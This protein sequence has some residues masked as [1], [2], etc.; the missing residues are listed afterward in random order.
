MR[1]LLLSLLLLVF[2]V[3]LRADAVADLKTR[4]GALT[5]QASVKAG[6]SFTFWSKVGDDK[7]P[8]VQEASI[9]LTAEDG[10]QGL[11]VGWSRD[12]IQLLAAEAL[13]KNGDPEK[14]TPTRRAID[15]FGAAT[16]T[17]FLNAAPELLNN[18]NRATL[19]SEKTDTW[20]GQPAQLLTF[21]L[22]PALSER[23][24]RLIKDVYDTA[25]IWVGADG[26][27][28]AAHRTQR[29]KGRAMLVVTFEF[30]FNEQSEYAQVG[31][32]L[33]VVRRSEE[34]NNSGAGEMG[35]Q[36]TTAVLTVIAW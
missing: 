17:R 1:A 12:L 32:R 4:L 34:R 21:Q 20:Q 29:L 14:S 5:G 28:L 13:A 25:K 24:L 11:H 15:E 10:P 18:L 35:Q 27:P 2:G 23:D 19:V 26:L 22:S 30:A 6:A 33:V 16:L 36:K 7:K 8:V 9:K 31:D 3:Q